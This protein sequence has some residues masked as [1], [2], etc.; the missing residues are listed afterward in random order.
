MRVLGLIGIVAILLGS[1]SLAQA[2]PLLETQWNQRGDDTFAKFSP[3]HWR[4]GCWSTA[5]AQILYHHRLA[6]SGSNSY[7]CTTYGYHISE[8]FDSHTF[9]WRLFTNQLVAGSTPVESID[10]VA[11]YSYY[12]SVVIEKD[13]GTGTYVLGHSARADALEDHYDCT[14]EYHYIGGSYDMNDLKADIVDQID[15]GCPLMVHLYDGDAGG[16]HAVAI[17]DYIDGATFKVHINM[18]WGGSSDGYYDI[19]QPILDYETFRRVVMITPPA[20]PPPDPWP[21]ANPDTYSGAE[22]YSIDIDDGPDDVLANDTD[23]VI[24]H[25]DLEAYKITNPAHGTVALSSDGSFLYTPQADYH[26][27]DSFTYRAFNGQLYSDPATVNLTIAPVNDPPVAE[28]DEY[29]CDQNG[30][31][32]KYAHEGVLANDTDVETPHGDL[33]AQ[34]VLDPEHGAITGWGPNGW[35]TYTP[36]PGWYGEDSFTYKAFDDEDWSDVATVT[37]EVLAGLRIPGDASGNGVVDEQ[38]A[39]IVA[40]Y[41][42]QSASGPSMGDFNGDGI[43]GPADAAI[44]VANW[45]CGVG[46]AGQTTVPEPGIAALLVFGFLTVLGRRRDFAAG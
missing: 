12:T 44:L 34:R 15:A 16:Y 5:F 36:D 23:P 32:T 4:L 43:V 11:L 30:S 38:D 35:F 24:P 13:F 39:A 25:E 19:A 29:E 3:D 31:I 41:W 28:D 27:S 9:D 17:D 21:T 40:G 6:P 33:T 42:G 14:T 1:V 18:G 8:D 45:G 46:E 37:I 7:N 2:A 26:G 22:D 20:T 10:E